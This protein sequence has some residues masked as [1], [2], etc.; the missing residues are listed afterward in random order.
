MVSADVNENA[1]HMGAIEKAKDRLA[2]AK[3]ALQ[4]LDGR[5][6]YEASKRAWY[7]F[8][9]ASNAVF[10]VLEQGAKGSKSQ[11]WYG[12]KK[13][14]RESEPLLQYLHQARNADEHGIAPVTTLEKQKL[15]LVQDGKTVGAIENIVGNK[16]VFRVPEGQPDKPDLSKINEMRLYPARAKLISVTN[17]GVKYHPP[18]KFK[19]QDIPDNSPFEVG[20]L[21]MDFIESMLSEAEGL[22]RTP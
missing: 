1:M 16:G 9:I 21:A 3:S 10:A 12:K 22:S 2:A 14:E 17:R 20:K 15:V 18:T 5:P 7:D 13:H 19:G 8:L 11:P 6:N 4:V